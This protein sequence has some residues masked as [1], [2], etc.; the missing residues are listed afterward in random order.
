MAGASPAIGLGSLVGSG[1]GIGILAMLELTNPV[2]VIV[3]L[4][5]SG[6]WVTIKIV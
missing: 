4:N 3:G 5:Y 2:L 6:S 1:I